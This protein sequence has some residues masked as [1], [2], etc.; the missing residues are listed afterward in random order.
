MGF[1][2]D[3]VLLDILDKVGEKKKYEYDVYDMNNETAESIK[4]YLCKKGENG[5]RLSHISNGFIIMER[6]L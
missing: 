4:K 6:E 3:K 5:W 2:T 1:Y